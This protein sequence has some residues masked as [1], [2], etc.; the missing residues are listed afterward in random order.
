[1]R[2]KMKYQLYFSLFVYEKIDYWV[3][4]MK[5]FLLRSDTI[6]IHCWNEEK[7]IVEEVQSVLKGFEKTKEYDLTI[8]KGKI[9][10]DVVNYLSYNNIDIEGKIKW[11]SIFL[12]NN[13]T[14]IFHSEHWGMEF[15]APDV[16]KKDVA[17]IKSIM[18]VETNFHQYI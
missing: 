10:P 14:T 7:L 1:M 6:E 4:L 12:I 13:T 3:P 16:Y 9:T 17:F 5:Y 15:F 11:F 8:F 18:P 2:Y